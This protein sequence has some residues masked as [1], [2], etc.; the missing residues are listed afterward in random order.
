MPFQ[1]SLGSLDLTEYAELLYERLY[2]VYLYLCMGSVML[3]DI[4]RL[5]SAGGG[6]EGGPNK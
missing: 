6:V 4:S 1:R 2:S 5:S 3:Y